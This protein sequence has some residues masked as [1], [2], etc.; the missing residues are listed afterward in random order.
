ARPIGPTSVVGLM[1]AR[2]SGDM[3]ATDWVH[4]A[5]VVDEIGRLIASG[6]IDGPEL[7]RALDEADTV[8][9]VD[10]PI[11]AGLE[12]GFCDTHPWA[13]LEALVPEAVERGT[14]AAIE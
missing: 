4:F 13:L 6:H 5:R 14:R 3:H 1:R 10:E 12:Q 7:E 9:S 8:L 2:E 11:L